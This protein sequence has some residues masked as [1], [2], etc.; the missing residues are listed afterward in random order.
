M[1]RSDAE[2]A[3]RLAGREA[4]GFAR[5]LH[6]VGRLKATPRTGWL[7]RGIPAVEA[8]SVADHSFRTA[9]LAWLAATLA[10]GLD[11]SRVLQLA[12]LHDLAE[13]V[14]GDMPPY[15]PEE[16]PPGEDPAAQR[17]FLDR[18]HVRSDARRNAKRAAEA[19]ARADLLAD[20]PSTLA[21]PLAALWAE[22][23]EGASP[24][25]RF[26]KQADKLETY[27]QSREYQA[28]GPERP[29]ASFAA[30][31]AAVIT[32]PVLIALRDAIGGLEVGSDSANG[33]HPGPQ[34]RGEGRLLATRRR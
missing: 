1:T 5:F 30:E 32:E 2:S 24:E 21:K 25:A 27:L 23:E 18:L 7:D 22:L 3:A 17:A 9:V 10:P 4:I 31:V 20:L 14:T 6:R 19:A 12:V 34:G 15:D 13:A 29:V 11:A 26:V 28:V 33:P 8:E 16:I